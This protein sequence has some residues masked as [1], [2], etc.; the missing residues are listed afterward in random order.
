[1]LYPVEH[2]SKLFLAGL[3]GQTAQNSIKEIRIDYSKRW[4]TGSFKAMT[5]AYSSSPYFNFI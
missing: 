2:T 5:A 4:A 3:S 1:M